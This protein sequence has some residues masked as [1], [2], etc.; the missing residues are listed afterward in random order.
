MEWCALVVQQMEVSSRAARYVVVFGHGSIEDGW[1]VDL[2]WM[3]SFDDL[4]GQTSTE[5]CYVGNN[6]RLVGMWA[7]VWQLLGESLQT[8][9]VM[10]DLEGQS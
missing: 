8:I 6:R 5:R 2:D 9:A 1:S 4:N 10:M 7:S 3:R